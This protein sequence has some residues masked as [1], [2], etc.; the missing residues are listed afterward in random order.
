MSD[1]KKKKEKV[2]YID[3]GRTIADMSALSR[4]RGM[5]ANGYVRP[6]STAK[7]KW[8]TYW[9]AVRSMLIPM[10]IAIGVITLLFLVAFIVFGG[11]PYYFGEQ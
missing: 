4:G 9:S 8:K 6:P 1:K 10:F 7:D 3:D 5:D 11:I 2:K